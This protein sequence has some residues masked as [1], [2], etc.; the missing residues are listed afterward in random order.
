MALTN[1]TL[2]DAMNATYSVQQAWYDGQISRFE[3]VKHFVDDLIAD[4]ED[5]HFE[6]IIPSINMLT[7]SIGEGV[8]I[9]TAQNV[10]D[11]RSALV[12]TTWM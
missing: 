6:E 11:L 1:K 10:S 9:Q 4:L 3:I 12:K 8:T 7:T 5:H 2:L